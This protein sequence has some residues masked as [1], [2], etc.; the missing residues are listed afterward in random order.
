MVSIRPPYPSSEDVWEEQP[1]KMNDILIGQHNPPLQ[2]EQGS[3]LNPEGI[4]CK[5]MD[6]FG[7]A[8]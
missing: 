1:I 4:Y 2:P 8:G 5:K 6:N 7:L 3:R